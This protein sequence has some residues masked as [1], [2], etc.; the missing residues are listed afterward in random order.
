MVRLY[1]SVVLFFCCF[2]VLAQSTSYDFEL[3]TL[4]DKL[5]STAT[6]LKS[7]T[8]KILAVDFFSIHCEPCKKALPEFEKLYQEYKT[9]GL[10]FVVVAV[11]VEEDRTAEFMKIREYFKTNKYSFPVVF[12]KYSIVGKKYGIVD[13]NGSATIP[14]IFIFNKNWNLVLRTERHSEAI[15]KIKNQK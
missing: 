15:K 6:V 8:T 13:K 9:K 10:S 2:S 11:S 5:Y 4:N 7:E 12:D 1:F 14:Q 3:Y